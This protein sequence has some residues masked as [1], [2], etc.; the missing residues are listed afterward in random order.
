MRCTRPSLGAP[1]VSLF[2]ACTLA[3]FAR[4][5]APVPR[6][7]PPPQ[8][9]A[10]QRW[11][12]LRFG[13][14]IHWGPVSLTGKEIG[15]S[16]GTKDLPV[17]EYDSLYK[18][19]DPQKFNADEW[20]AIARSAGMKY[21]I[22]TTKHHDG[23][24]LWD[25]KYSD[26]NIMKTPFHRD[27][28]KELSEAC[29]RQGMPFGVYYSVTDWYDP[30]WPLASPGGKVKRAV[31][32]LDAYEKYLQNQVAELI[33]HYGPL[34]TIWND[35]PAMYARR[36]ADTIRLVR[37]LQPDI[38]LNDR[39]GD[40][41]DYATPEQRVGAYN[42]TRPWESCMT[43]SAH[44]QWSWGGDADGVKDLRTCIQMLVRVSGGDGNMLLNVGPRPDGQIDREQRDRLAQI[45]QWTGKYGESIYATRGGPFK[46]TEGWVSTHRDNV[47]YVHVLKW[48]GDSVR[49]PPVDAK[50]VRSE[51][52]TG[53]RA[54]VTRDQA[55]ITIRVPAAD[56]QGLDTIVK[57]EF[58]ALPSP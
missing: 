40:G 57:L 12:D 20:V 21:V 39:T 13:M 33:S 18:R 10:V 27:V 19:F 24:C 43:L 51:L 53:G 56:R 55:G 26:Y 37:K 46:P 14:F 45:G 52:L 15:W 25:T 7:W 54:D 31:Y 5:A 48:N 50:V 36:G 4:A 3:P 32:D 17:E 8:P 22:L 58:D 28:V 29:K 41:G 38:L 23:F 11:K 49:L 6:D 2:L 35:M 34:L 42:T 44:N 16:R 9:Q 47:V 30:R 1:V